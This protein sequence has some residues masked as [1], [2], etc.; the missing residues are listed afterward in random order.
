MHANTNDPVLLQTVTRAIDE[1]TPTSTPNTT[2][3][4]SMQS[5][6]DSE[7]ES[8]TSTPEETLVASNGNEKKRKA[9]KSSK[10]VSQPSK[11][12]IVT[13]ST[14]DESTIDSNNS[15][16]KK[17]STKKAKPVEKPSKKKIAFSSSEDESA[18]STGDE[19]EICVLA[20]KDVAELMNGVT[21]SHE[22]VLSA[23]SMGN[24]LVG[25]MELNAYSKHLLNRIS[26]SI[27][28]Q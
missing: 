15:G 27:D 18:S 20:P 1:R 23:T 25:I 22:Q 24:L 11:K 7:N 19:K 3:D 6:E 14:E 12:K 4:T 5:K 21:K 28:V 17:K 16:K 13:A 26:N 8:P 2:D 10:S 9:T